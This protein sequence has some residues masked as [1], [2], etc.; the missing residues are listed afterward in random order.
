MT[1]IEMEQLV[2]VVTALLCHRLRNTDSDLCKQL[3]ATDK[4]H[5]IEIKSLSCTELCEIAN[6]TPRS[7]QAKKIVAAIS[8]KE[9][10]VVCHS[11]FDSR[12]KPRQMKY[13]FWKTCK[14]A[15]DKCIAYGITFKN[16]TPEINT[17]NYH[18]SK[19]RNSSVIRE[20]ITLSKAQV[21]VAEGKDIP[22][23]AIVTP[24]AYDYIKKMT[25]R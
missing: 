16:T 2:Q 18:K 22:L 15:Y 4:P 11:E 6:L 9:T 23:H 20:V 3:E 8:R 14:S 5:P 17:I 19:D 21:L 12:K 13:A 24:L 1:V 7:E 25:R 10:V